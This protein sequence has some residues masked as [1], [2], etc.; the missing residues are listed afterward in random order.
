MNNLINRLGLLAL[1]L[2]I[3]L[4][5]GTLGFMVLESLSPFDALYFTILTVATVGYGDIVPVS[6]GGRILAI[7]IVITGVG[8]FTAL[9]VNTGGLLWERQANK[10]RIERR[11]I[12]IGLFYSELGNKLLE[13]FLNKEPSIMIRDKTLIKTD[14]TEKEFNELRTYMQ[15]YEFRIDLKEADFSKL[16]IL[17]N[18]K[19]DLLV[20]L[21]ENPSLMEHELFTDLLMATFHL[22]EE[23][24]LREDVAAC[25]NDEDLAHLGNDIKRVYSTLSILWVSY[26]RDLKQRY[27]YLFSLAIRNNPFNEKRCVIVK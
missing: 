15:K 13:L 23:L 10:S 25:D 18:E 20:S 21:L 26:I 8:T 2:V 11:N 3:L 6:I 1:I 27:P 19:T 9:L 24:I 22:R 14:W 16:K 17:L 12:L 7:F 5:A 4:A